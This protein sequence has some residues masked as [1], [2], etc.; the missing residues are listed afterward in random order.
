MLLPS[1]NLFK[2]VHLQP[3]NVLEDREDG[4]KL[5]ISVNYLVLRSIQL[6][7]LYLLM[8]FEI[9]G[10]VSL[11]SRSALDPEDRLYSAAEKNFQSGRRNVAS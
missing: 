9:S 6:S 5:L 1:L 3:P 7:L 2:L 8:L 4:V 10:E 11:I